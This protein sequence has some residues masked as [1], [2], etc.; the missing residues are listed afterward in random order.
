MDRSNRD[1]SGLES[2]PLFVLSF[3]LSFLPGKCFPMPLIPIVSVLPSLSPLLNSFTIR[4]WETVR[5]PDLEETP[6]STIYPLE[7]YTR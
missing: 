4:S 2:F 6:S 3:F 1:E 7:I 5:S